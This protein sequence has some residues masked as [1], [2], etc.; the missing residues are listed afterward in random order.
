MYD[1]ILA[2]WGPVLCTRLFQG[3]YRHVNI[4][5]IAIY[6]DMWSDLIG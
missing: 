6:A 3:V 1:E 4:V 2:Q 5:N